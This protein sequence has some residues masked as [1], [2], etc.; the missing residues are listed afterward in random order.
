MT[1]SLA[2]KV[3]AKMGEKPKEVTA[4]EIGVSN[5]SLNNVLKGKKVNKKTASKYATYLGITED[6]VLAL[7]KYAVLTS[8]RL[9]KKRSSIK[10]KTSAASGASQ[11]TISYFGVQ[12]KFNSQ[13]ELESFLSKSDE[14]VTLNLGGMEKGFK[15]LSEVKKWIDSQFG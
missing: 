10:V 14:A 2:D 9:K 12:K 4:K 13:K 15:D 3:K 1:E 8:K 7:N 11:I 6:E 5:P